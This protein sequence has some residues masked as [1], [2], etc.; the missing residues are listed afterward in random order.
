MSLN[1]LAQKLGPLLTA[2]RRFLPAFAFF[3]GF[4]WDSV[5]MGRVV[6]F[7]DLLVLTTY[8]FGAGLILVLL[9][10]EIKPQWQNW[11]AFLI[12]FFFGGLFSALVV[13]YFKSSA[14]G[15]TLLVVVGLIA[16]LVANEFL[17]EKYLSRTLSWTLFAACG[18][19][20]LNFLIPHFVHSIK[21]IWF[22][23][24]CVI[25]LTLVFGI[26]HFANAPQRHLMLLG[27]KKVQYRSDLRQL[28]PATAVVLL[29][30]V[31]YQLQLIPPVP[32]VLK[33]SYVCKD[34]SKKAGFYQCQ[35]EKQPFWRAL[36]IGKDVIHFTE[37]EKIYSLSA[38]F[39]PKK[40]AVDL[41][42]RWWLRDEKSGRWLARGVVPLPMVGGRKEGW[43]T[44]SY[45]R[46]ALRPGRW[47][48]ETAIA[49]G[50]VLS[51]H[52]FT[53]KIQSESAPTTYTVQVR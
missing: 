53:A 36:G 8:Y 43:R 42:Q 26:R 22:Y 46:A 44:Y 4:I 47:K 38:V 16:L 35:V 23:L 25:S 3:C 49:D 9:V 29:L 41:E 7:F 33:E 5:T 34:F 12:Q 40:V 21:A 20:Y 28:A 14:S 50:A 19:M 17:A 2:I 45:I 31:F 27:R 15:Y 13:F 1:W 51:G 39:A 30:I 11:F 6:S 37:G 52:H 24:S 48:V 32:L 18:T 10:R